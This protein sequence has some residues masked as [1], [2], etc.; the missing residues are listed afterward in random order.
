MSLDT[1]LAGLGVIGTIAFAVT[2]VMAVTTRRVDFFLGPCSGDD[3]L[4]R[5]RNHS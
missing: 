1:I 3:Y 2:G 5:P 4:D